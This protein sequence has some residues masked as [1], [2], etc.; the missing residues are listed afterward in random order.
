MAQVRKPIPKTP[1]QEVQDKIVPYELASY[2]KEP[3]VSKPNR[4]LKVSQKGSREKNFSVKLIDIDTAVL[5]HIKDNI[6]PTVYSNTEL[7]DVPVIYAYPERWVAMQ[8]EGFLRDVSGKIIAPLIV[9]NRTDV[10][11]NRNVGRNLDGNL[12]QNVHIFERQFTNKNAYDNFNVLNN[13]QP[14]KEMM[15]VAHPDYVTITYE[16]NVYADFVEQS[17]RILEAIQ[18]AENSYWGDKNRYYFRVNIESFPTT[19]QYAAEE[20]RTVVSKITMKLHG[21]LIP[22]TINAYLSHDMS[23]VSKG[24]VIFSEYAVD[25]LIVPVNVKKPKT[26]NVNPLSPPIITPASF[27]AV[28]QYL[29]TNNSA[30]AVVVSTNQAVIYG[31]HIMVAPDPLPPT[32]KSQFIVLINGINIEP[33]FFNLQQV[34]NDISFTFNTSLSGLGFELNLPSSPNPDSVLIIGKFQ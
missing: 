3:M 4:A 11:K 26:I 31:K 18:Y 8:K 6:K 9:V 34:G 1:A 13:R 28:S 15:V 2:G 20:E 22:D 5:E 27:A 29:N 16:L 24:Q 7:I 21:Y 33:N 17:N 19:V 23:Y 25:D 12:A 32:G 14:V 30:L 10:A